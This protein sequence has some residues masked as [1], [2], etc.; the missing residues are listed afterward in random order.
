MGNLVWS[1][2]VSVAAVVATVVLVVLGRGE[3]EVVALL[4]IAFAVL[5]LREK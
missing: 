3:A 4:A 1:A 2:M 5:S